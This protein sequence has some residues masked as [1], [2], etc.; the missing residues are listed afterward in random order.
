MPDYRIL[1]SLGNPVNEGF[2]K[3][4]E[5]IGYALRSVSGE[6]I[7]IDEV[8]GDVTAEAGQF[9]NVTCTTSDITIALP[10]PA[11]YVGASIFVRKADATAW[12]VIVTGVAEMAFQFSSMH[13]ISIGTEWVIT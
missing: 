13:L 9:L 6:G 10:D 5:G 8:I 4:M 1:G 7:N 11:L 12:Q 2:G 3:I